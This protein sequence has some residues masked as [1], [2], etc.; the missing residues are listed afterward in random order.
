MPKPMQDLAPI[1]AKLPAGTRIAS[2]EFALPGWTPVA[3]REVGP[4]RQP[5]RLYVVG[6]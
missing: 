5:V 3:T 2:V 4:L 6:R 1:L